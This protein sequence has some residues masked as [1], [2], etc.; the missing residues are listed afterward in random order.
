[1]VLEDLEGKQFYIFTFIPMSYWIV[2]ID[3]ENFALN[4]KFFLLGVGIFLTAFQLFYRKVAEE[5]FGKTVVLTEQ[6]LD[7]IDLIKQNP[8][9]FIFA[10]ISLVYT[11]VTFY[12]MWT[13]AKSDVIWLLISL[14][15]IG[16]LYFSF[17]VGSVLK[18][19]AQRKFKNYNLL[20]Y[21]R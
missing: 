2:L 15:L 14:D 18:K 9:T 1:M 5:I 6:T 21:R 13:G 11:I 10:A 7:K 17:S 12:F 4:L 3:N 19:L 16:I 8:L 20:L